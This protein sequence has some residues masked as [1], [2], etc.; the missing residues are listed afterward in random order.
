MRREDYD[1]EKADVWQVCG[2]RTERVKLQDLKTSRPQDL[3]TSRPQDLK[4]SRPGLTS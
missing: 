2:R 4:T 3:K 1:G